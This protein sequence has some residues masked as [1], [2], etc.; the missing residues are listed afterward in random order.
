MITL[1]VNLN[2]QPLQSLEHSQERSQEPHSTLSTISMLINQH[3]IIRTYAQVARKT[4]SAFACAS[5]DISMAKAK[6]K[7][8]TS[9]VAIFLFMV[10][11][12]SIKTGSSK[13]ATE[14]KIAI[15]FATMMIFFFEKNKTSHSSSPPSSPWCPSLLSSLALSPPSPAPPV[16]P[17]RRH[18]YS[19]TVS[20][21][22]WRFQHTINTDSYLQRRCRPFLAKPLN[23]SVEAI[24]M[25]TAISC[26][27]HVLSAG[28]EVIMP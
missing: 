3:K 21:S 4:V 19:V 16:L 28:D 8:K 27:D 22:P 17:L 25:F 26:K 12:E 23:K 24:S 13:M 1:L 14:S 11:K 6:T 2:L 10:I 15:S 9:E 7:I 18:H 20:G 5:R